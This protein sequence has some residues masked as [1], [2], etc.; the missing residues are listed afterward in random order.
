MREARRMNVMADATISVRL[1]EERQAAL[2][3]Q[4]RAALADAVNARFKRLSA[5]I[6]LQPVA[7]FTGA[8]HHLKQRSV[9]EASET[10]REPGAGGTAARISGVVDYLFYLIYGLITLRFLLQ[11][12]GEPTGNDFTQFVASL[13]QRLIAPLE[14]LVPTPSNSSYRIERSYLLAPIAYLSLHLAIN[15]IFRLIAGRKEMVSYRKVAV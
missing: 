5:R 4:L 6:K 8:A 10:D 11:L 15:G 7:E 1:N 13:S 12:M 3:Q 14:G 2:H 9:Q